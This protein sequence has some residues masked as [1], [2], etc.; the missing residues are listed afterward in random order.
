M[1][2][3]HSQSAPLSMCLEKQATT[4]HVPLH[5]LRMCGLSRSRSLSISRSLTHTYTDIAG[6][7]TRRRETYSGR[8]DMGKSCSG[9]GVVE[10]GGGEGGK[11]VSRRGTEGAAMRR[12]SP[13]RRLSVVCDSIMVAL[14][15]NGAVTMAAT[16]TVAA[17]GRSDCP[18]PV[19]KMA[20]MSPVPTTATREVALAARA[21][22]LRG[23]HVSIGTMITPPP[24]PTKL[25]NVPAMPPTGRPSAAKRPLLPACPPPPAGAP[26]PGFLSDVFVSAA[27]PKRLFI[28][29]ACTALSWLTDPRP[30]F[31]SLS[32]TRGEGA[33][34]KIF[35]ALAQLYLT[36]MVGQP[37]RTPSKWRA[38]SSAPVLPRGVRRPAN[39]LTSLLLWRES[40]HGPPIDDV[41]RVPDDV[42]R[43]P[44]DVTRVS[45]DVMSPTAPSAASPTG[46]HIP[47]ACAR[48]L[49][50]PLYNTAR[51]CRSGAS[52]GVGA[53]TRF[54]RSLRSQLERRVREQ[55]EQVGAAR[56]RVEEAQ[57]KIDALRG[58]QRAT[59]VFSPAKFPEVENRGKHEVHSTRDD[60]ECMCGTQSDMSHILR[61]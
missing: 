22:R 34:E 59:R 17:A 58:S 29:H 11:R 52:L 19:Y 57:R 60:C 4:L 31:F 13:M 36:H 43:V 25:P 1:P 20:A 45:D 48:T 50:L 8:C 38:A 51:A 16:A 21:W 33:A 7:V 44:D 39:I 49:C 35:R 6:P 37:Y 27:D 10:G 55:R 42:T 5:G 23:L 40:G 3:K 12:K 56:R 30:S 2:G 54:A 26:A 15:P 18:C 61:P 28:V 9:L 32:A 46:W 41:T 14:A 47:A 24:T 53:L